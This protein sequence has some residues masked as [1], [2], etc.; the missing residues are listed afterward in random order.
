MSKVFIS[1]CDPRFNAFLYAVIL[2][3][4]SGASLTVLSL[5]ARHNGDPWEEAAKYARSPG[6]STIANFSQLLTDV[7]PCSPSDGRIRTE[8]VRLLDLLPAPSVADPIAQHPLWPVIMGLLK[9]L[10]EVS[11]MWIHNDR[12]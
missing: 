9:R 7:M 4:P 12:R 6:K 10:K 8:A 5:L 1:S 2:E 11:E 3:E